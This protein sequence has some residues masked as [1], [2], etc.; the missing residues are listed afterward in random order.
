[1][2]VIGILHDPLIYSFIFSLTAASSVLTQTQNEVREVCRGVLDY[3][4]LRTSNARPL[5]CRLNT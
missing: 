4:P 2:L 5:A 1:M 3:Y